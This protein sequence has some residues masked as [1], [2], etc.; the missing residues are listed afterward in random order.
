MTEF[1]AEFADLLRAK[2][3]LLRAEMV[4]L[5]DDQRR[6]ADITHRSDVAAAVGV[7]LA[8]YNGLERGHTQPSEQ[9]LGALVDV[10]EFTDDE[11]LELAAALA[12]ARRNAQLGVDPSLQTLMRSWSTT[13]SFICSTRFTVLA[14]NRVAQALSPMFDVGANVIRE[15][16]FDPDAYEM[17]RNVDEVDEFTAAWARTFADVHAG[18]ASWR[19]T[20]TEISRR[21]PRFRDAWDRIAAPRGSGELL[22]E[23]PAVGTLDLRFHRFQ[24]AGCPDQFLITLHAAPESPSEAGMRLLK[25][26]A[27]PE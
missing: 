9:I 18:D 24:P 7:S 4:L 16:Y 23:H 13:A 27:P 20:V 11:A 25:E 10:L 15:M 21:R 3:E 26:F 2:R 5:S 1:G 14:A 6:M 22:L 17:I 12:A 19:R 8:Y